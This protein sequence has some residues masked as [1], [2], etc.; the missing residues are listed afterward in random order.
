[1]TH[2]SK[3][4]ECCSKAFRDVDT[5]HTGYISSKDLPAL[6]RNCCD[7]KDKNC[8]EEDIQKMTSRFKTDDKGRISEENFKTTIEQL[9]Q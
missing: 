1:M 5:Q 7:E 6:L 8:S 9:T 4:S 2:I 3:S